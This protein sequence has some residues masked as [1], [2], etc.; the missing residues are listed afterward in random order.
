VN[1]LFYQFVHEHFRQ[2]Q[3]K[4]IKISEPDLATQIAQY[5]QEHFQK[6]I[7]METMAKRFHYSTHYL[8][9]VFKRKYGCSPIEYVVQTRINRSKSLLA[10]TDASIRE[11]AENVG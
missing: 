7:A 5:I 9:K 8:V 10:D 11:V 1:G 2:L 3:M 4:E 6:P